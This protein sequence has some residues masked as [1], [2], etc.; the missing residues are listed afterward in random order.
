VYKEIW[1]T[2]VWGYKTMPLGSAEHSNFSFLYRVFCSS[3]TSAN[4]KNQHSTD[5]IL[6]YSIK[7]L[8]KNTTYVD[9]VLVRR[10]TMGLGMRRLFDESGDRSFGS[11]EAILK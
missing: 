6:R 5:K 3:C 9:N 4:N 7:I 10:V 8:G 11:G 1:T 2:I